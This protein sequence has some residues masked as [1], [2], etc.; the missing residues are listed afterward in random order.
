M[1]KDFSLQVDTLEELMKERESQI[2]LMKQ[3][4]ASSP[5]MIQQKQF[6]VSVLLFYN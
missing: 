1:T 6:Q 4:L 5:A 3:R 2:E